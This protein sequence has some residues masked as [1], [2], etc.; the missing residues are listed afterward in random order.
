MPEATYRRKIKTVEELCAIIGARPREKKV[1]MCH[2]TFD[3]VHPGHVR[4]LMYARGKGDILIASLTCDDHIAKANFRPYVPEEL[5]AMNLAALEPVDYVIIDRDPTPLRNLERI[6][7]DYFAKG[8]EYVDGGLH[9]RTRE[10]LKV[11]ESYGGELIFTPGDIVYSSSALIEM[12]P[13]SIAVDKLIS[14]M[15]AEGLGFDDLRRA[16]DALS[17]VRVHVVGDTIVDSHTHTTLIGGNTKTPTF[18]VRHE[19]RIDFT[20]G[21]AVV[22]KHLRAAGA[23]VTFSTVLGDDSLKDF[24]L[25]DLAKAGV[26]CKAII[27]PTRP[28]T[29]KNAFIAGGYRLLKVDT[30]DNRAISEKILNQL[31]AQMAE[32]PVDAV[33]FSDFRHGIFN[34]HTIPSLIK[35]LPAGVYR[36]ADSQV[37]SRWGNILDFKGFDLITPNE[38]EARFALGDQDLTVRLLAYELFQR[39][40]SRTL[41]LKLGDRGVITYRTRPQVD[42]V[43]S[44][45]AVDSHADTVVD[46]VGAGDALLAYATLAM[47]TTR[48]EVV[49]TVLGALAAAVEC[50]HDGNIPV[51][52]EQVMEKLAKLERQAAYS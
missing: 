24:V 39:S 37:A 50:E 15:E 49:A 40:E 22:A 38:R 1:I 28:T 17:G 13:P 18:S 32:T 48:N 33:V 52:P 41:M 45:F 36:V 9:P 4:H 2:G 8:Y 6:Q 20:G 5:R 27:D 44:F 23:D 34:R 19:R 31:L 16:L 3:V 30:L 11:L 25:D 43:R 46:A 14:V 35:G 12:A 21:A 26:R 47:I 51:G 7:P 42:D 10:E 29:N